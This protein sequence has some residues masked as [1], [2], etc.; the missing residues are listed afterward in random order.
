M[1]PGTISGDVHQFNLHGPVCDLA[2]TVS[3][4]LY[5]A[6]ALEGAIKRVTLNPSQVFGRLSRLGT[7]RADAAAEIAFLS[8]DEGEFRL[9]DALGATRT[10]R[11][12][13]HA[14][15]TVGAESLDRAASIPVE[16][17]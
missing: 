1:L 12:M 8:L 3:K 17:L 5:Q 2:T 15:A 9:T 11:R 4:F 13:L 7:L 6:L 10:G 16:R 14:V